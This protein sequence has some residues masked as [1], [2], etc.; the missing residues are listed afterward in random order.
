MAA[1][2]RNHDDSTGPYGRVAVLAL[3]RLGDLITTNHVIRRLRAFA[4]VESVE[5]I[6]FSE[7]R[8]A[9]AF[10]SREAILHP[11]P[12]NEIKSAR[13]LHALAP[14][15]RLTRRLAEILGRS[16]FDTVV[17]LTSTPFACRLAPTLTPAADARH[18]FGPWIDNAGRAH[19]ETPY[20]VYLNGH[21]IAPELNVFAHQDLLSAGVGIQPGSTH[22]VAP[23]EAWIAH[24]E[25]DSPSASLHETVALHPFS[26]D[27]EKDWYEDA[28]HPASWQAIV[29]ELAH[30]GIRRVLLLGS[31][32]QQDRLLQLIKN[33]KVASSLVT[34]DIATSAEI[35][36]ASAGLITVDTVSAHLATRVG[37]R[38]VI[39]RRGKVCR[40][41]FLPGDGA[42]LVDENHR[43]ENASNPHAARQIADAIIQHLLPHLAPPSAANTMGVREPAGISI[44][45]CRFSGHGW[46]ETFVPSWLQASETSSERLVAE[47]LWRKVWWNIW[48]QDVVALRVN[49]ETVLATPAVDAA[50]R[51]RLRSFLNLV[52]SAP[53]NDVSILGH[54][55][56]VVKH[57]LKPLLARQSTVA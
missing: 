7:T 24:Q 12:Y 36:R 1:P 13:D 44:H 35:I 34:V 22:L 31:P 49:V 16:N 53:G 9:A 3:Q 57:V 48:D 14:Y 41:A 28:D 25:F 43:L 47:G 21:G 52:E 15:A 29:N 10:F 56:P 20:L 39:L 51:F 54:F 11:L 32:P 27:A 26:S 8:G 5:V 50:A 18:L 40:H 4:D 30:R 17:N 37:Q 46:R 19:F 38:S 42:L 23:I 55:A 6:H 2:N 33:W 45:Q